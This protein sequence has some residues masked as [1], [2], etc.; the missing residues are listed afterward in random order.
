MS[1]RDIRGASYMDQY[2]SQYDNGGA[3]DTQKSSGGMGCCAKCGKHTLFAVNFVMLLIGVALIVVV[4]FVK[5]N[6]GS[7]GGL[8]IV[9][10]DT[11][12][13]LA[14]IAGVFIIIVSFLGCVGATTHSKC[15]LVS[16]AVALVACLLFEL[17]FIIIIF[18]DDQMVRNNAEKQWNAW[19]A[20]QQSTYETDNDCLGFDDCYT[21]I[22][23]TIK[24]NMFIVGGVTIGI[25]VYQLVMTVIA[26]CLCTKSDKG[27][28][29][30]DPDDV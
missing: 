10:N 16:F 11:V 5:E 8:P 3:Y 26:C 15:I 18:A 9:L 14:V 30:V 23:Q 13:W 6:G 17:V 1:T 2:D 29:S 12:V 21:S 27:K 28:A 22:E 20:E 7:G 24:N 25:F 19:S 4:F